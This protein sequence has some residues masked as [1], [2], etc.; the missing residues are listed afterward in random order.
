MLP[1]PG[2]A[3]DAPAAGRSAEA[4]ACR[5]QAAARA[6]D[7][8]TPRMAVGERSRER[9][10]AVGERSRVPSERS[11]RLSRA[12][13]SVRQTPSCERGPRWG[14]PRADGGRGRGAAPA[15]LPRRAGASDRP[16]PRM[17]ALHSSFTSY[18]HHSVRPVFFM[19]CL[20][21]GKH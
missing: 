3:G 10:M 20:V 19:T 2:L 21:F 14:K 6:R 8:L 17:R 7:D 18:P 9:R 13:A 12:V 4:H 15:R 16:G 5:M 11:L 1:G